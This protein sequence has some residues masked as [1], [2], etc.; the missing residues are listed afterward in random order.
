[1]NR[2]FNDSICIRQKQLLTKIPFSKATLWRKVRNGTF[3][4]PFKL[5]EK[6]TV[7]QVSDIEEWLEKL[8]SKASGVKG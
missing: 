3:P 2:N 8:H 6:V 5:S 4:K 1:M 7:W